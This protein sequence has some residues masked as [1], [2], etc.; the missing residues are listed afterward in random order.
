MLAGLLKTVGCGAGAKVGAG[1]KPVAGASKAKPASKAKAAAVAAAAEESNSDN[2]DGEEV[3]ATKY[4]GG[5]Q[6]GRQQ[7][8]EPPKRATR[9]TLQESV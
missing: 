3:E 8:I 6:T 5:W 1:I 7:S 2:S 4:M 9:G